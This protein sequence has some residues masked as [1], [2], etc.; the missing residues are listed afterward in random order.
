MN[1]PVFV[2]NTTG[3]IGYITSQF[4][5]GAILSG[6][7]VHTNVESLECDG[8]FCA[9]DLK[10]LGVGYRDQPLASELVLVDETRFLSSQP[11]LGAGFFDYLSN[12]GA[13]RKLALIYANDDVNFLRFP[14]ELLT[15]LPHQCR[16]FTKNPNAVPVAWGFTLEGFEASKMRMGR[17]RDPRKIVQNFNPTGSQTVRE[18]VI[19]ALQ[20]TDLMDLSLDQRH[21]HGDEYSD[22]LAESQ[23]CLAMGGTFH[24]PKSDYYWMRERMD[25]RSLTIDVFPER[26]KTVGIMR[27]DSFRFWEAMAFGCLPI[28][29]D[30]EKHG[31][32]L[33]EMPQPW[34]HYIP[35][36]LGRVQDTVEK[37]NELAKSPDLLRFMSE[38]AAA[39]AREQVHPVSLY[40]RVIEKLS[41]LP[42]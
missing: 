38:S 11:D 12:L 37:I 31:F 6:A 8:R 30:L 33:P 32:V 17:L 13:S 3:T 21:L 2:F 9:A 1:D 29:L 26:S 34:L 40:K 7:S 36:D 23:F 15:F 5:Q 19:A 27:W 4:I 16:G 10:Q 42:A 18:A 25:E 35:L 20:V 24:W 14:G 41:S 39:W 28:Q 22:Q